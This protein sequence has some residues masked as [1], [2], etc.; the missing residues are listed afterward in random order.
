MSSCPKKFNF[1]GHFE[2]SELVCTWPLAK[3]GD[4]NFAT[5]LKISNNI[6]K[7]S[8]NF[9]FF[10][11]FAFFHAHKTQGI[12]R[13]FPAS[14]ISIL[15]NYVLWP[16]HFYCSSVFYKKIAT[17]WHILADVLSLFLRPKAYLP[18]TRTDASS[19]G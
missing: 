12:H 4:I 8:L 6:F 16:C 1:S 2:M 7:L 11:I 15:L 9:P 18:R 10:Q 5:V 3:I 14:L 17:F 13:A 19:S